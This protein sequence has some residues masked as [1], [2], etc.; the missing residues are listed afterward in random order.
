MDGYM[1][2]EL[3]VKKEAESN[4]TVKIIGYTSYLTETE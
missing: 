4:R 2:T 3:I 1:A